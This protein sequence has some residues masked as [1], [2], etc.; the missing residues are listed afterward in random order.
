MSQ[1]KLASAGDNIK[2]WDAAN[3]TLNHEY[4]PHSS[5]NVSDISWSYDGQFLASASSNGDKLMVALINYFNICEVSPKS[6]QHCVC[7]SKN[8]TRHLLSGGKNGELSLWDLKLHQVKKTFTGHSAPITKVQFN[9]NDSTILSGSARGDVILHNVVTGLASSPLRA[10]KVQAIRD[11][12]YSVTKRYLFATASD[13]GIINLWD[14]NSRNMV[15]SF[16]EAHNAPAMALAFSPVNEMLLT[17]VGLDKKIVCFD[18]KTKGPVKSLTSDQPLTSMDFL[19]DGVTLAV[20]STRGKISIFDL[21]QSA[22]P[23]RTFSAHK[24]SVQ[25]LSYQSIKA[26]ATNI[27][28]KNHGAPNANRSASLSPKRLLGTHTAT[29]S[30]S[31]AQSVSQI[32]QLANK[33]T[34]KKCLEVNGKNTDSTI[35]GDQTSQHQDFFRHR[36][37]SDDIFSPLHDESSIERPTNLRK[38]PIGAGNPNNLFFG[39]RPITAGLD[40]AETSGVLNGSYV[41][42]A[43]L[44]P[45]S[46]PPAPRRRSASFSPRTSRNVTQDRTKSGTVPES[47]VILSAS[48]LPVRQV[49][50]H[51]DTSHAMS[52][53]LPEALMPSVESTAQESVVP[54]ERVTKEDIQRLIEE[55]V[56]DLHELIN[57][58]YQQLRIDILKEFQIQKSEI[59]VLLQRYA[60]NE[61]L[62]SEVERLREENRRLQAK[63]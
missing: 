41:E 12:K 3:Y 62:V 16:K 7:F 2:L 45:L 1:I 27:A 17:S 36:N 44:R 48:K 58:K 25:G 37:L 6:D 49:H 51:K 54:L 18:V 10:P 61:D 50:S 15:H 24:S 60:I 20:G 34:I 4:S 22:T 28:A 11:L 59:E 53:V 31:L 40:D 46:P 52:P 32:P 8:T 63:F 13:D 38:Q 26:P 30:S 55:S 43:V 57:K 14:A 29:S 23:I 35:I 9:S 33:P 21:R 47:N 42:T 19:N 56:E 5:N 39:D